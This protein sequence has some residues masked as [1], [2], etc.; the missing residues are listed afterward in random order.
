MTIRHNSRPR[1][2]QHGR[3]IDPDARLKQELFRVA[4]ESLL[5]SAEWCDKKDKTWAIV[6][7]RRAVKMLEVIEAF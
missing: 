3:H 7:A 4:R 6:M 5:K 1:H 2:S